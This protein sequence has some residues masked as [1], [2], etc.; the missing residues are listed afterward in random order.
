MRERLA[1][2]P[3]VI[4]VSFA[5]IVACCFAA[6]LHWYGLREYAAAARVSGV[7]IVLEQ[8]IHQRFDKLEKL[9]GNGDRRGA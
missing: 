8:T 3:G 2:Q 9:L 7:L 4:A 6:A 1:F 5:V